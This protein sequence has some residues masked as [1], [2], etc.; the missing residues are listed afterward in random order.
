MDLR[1]SADKLNSATSG[2]ENCSTVKAAVACS[3]HIYENRFSYFL[4]GNVTLSSQAG[5]F[6]PVQ[7]FNC[8]QKFIEY[9]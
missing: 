4:S 1:L 6:A 9:Q 8:Y 5:G 2:D 7:D 3:S